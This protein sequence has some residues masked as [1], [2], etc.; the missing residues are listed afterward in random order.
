MPNPNL[1]PAI[2]NQELVQRLIPAVQQ[3]IAGCGNARGDGV[4]LSAPDS[5]NALL[6]V[7]A[8]VLESSPSCV[9]PMGLRL[10]A[11][12]AGKELAQLMRET[13][14]IRDASAC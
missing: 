6:M 12:A 1:W 13:R 5:V 2:E 4:E 11:E 10:T 3:A 7:L 9:T 14:Q 8:T